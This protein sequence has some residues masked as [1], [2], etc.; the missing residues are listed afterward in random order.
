MAVDAGYNVL[1]Q[2]GATPAS[3]AGQTEGTLT[4]DHAAIEKTVKSDYPNK[5]YAAGWTGWQMTCNAVAD[6]A[7]TNGLV[8]MESALNVPELVNVK[9]NATGADWTGQG[10]VTAFAYNASQD[11]MLTANV[12]VQG[13]AALTKA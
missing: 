4:R 1:F 11:G 9:F 3:V 5:T 10:F 2:V 7:D 12:T 6:V 13:S 8:A